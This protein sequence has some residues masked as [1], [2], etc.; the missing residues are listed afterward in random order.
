[1]VRVIV[2]PDLFKR[3]AEAKAAQRQEDLERLA[4]GADPMAI[5]RANGLAS[6]LDMSRARIIGRRKLKMQSGE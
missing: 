3:R 4:A 1:M 2:V 6:K 5:S